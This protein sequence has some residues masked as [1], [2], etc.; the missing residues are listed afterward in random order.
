MA[1]IVVCGAG[2]AG[3]ATAFHLTREGFTDI[4]IADPRPPLSLT[5]DKSTECYRDWWPHEPMVR[6]MSRSIELLDG[7]A[8]ESGNTFSLNRR[9][10][11]YLTADRDRLDTMSQQA[12]QAARAGAG[13]L[14]VH[15]S[16]TAH[17]TPSRL[18]GYA[19]GPRGADLFRNGNLLHRHFPWVS[20]QVVGAVHARNAGWLS[21]Q[22]LGTWMLEEA[23]AAGATLLATEVADVGIENDA[24]AGVTLGDGTRLSS[25]V[26]VNA[27]GPHLADVGRMVEIELPVHSEV[28]AKVAFRD[29]LGAFPRDAPMII[30]NDPQHIDWSCE[31]LG[32]L[33]DAERVDLTAA[34]PAGCHGRPE[35]GTDSTWAL[36]LWEYHLDVR[37]PEWPIPTDSLYTEVVLRGLSTMVPDLA[38]YRERLPHATVDGGYYTKTVENRPLAGPAGP[39]GSYVCG[40]LSGFG[41]MAACGVGELVAAAIAG[42]RLPDWAHWF[43]LR[44]YEDASYVRSI[45]AITESGQL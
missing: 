43:D 4:V 35:G 13:S 2:I 39:A 38:D 7:Y 18:E 37:P 12:E 32:Y 11:L 44:R 33:R 20:P 27:A 19:D 40:A 23:I 45:R 21:A 34:L 30:W 15:D 29:H 26:F 17:Y 42:K 41:I 31:E 14:R 5:S 25:R 1:E 36:G 3:I 8:A 28:H 22:R 10:Y 6:L 9:G 24:V 16:A